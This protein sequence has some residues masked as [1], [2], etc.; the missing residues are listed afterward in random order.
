MSPGPCTAAG[1]NLQVDPGTTRHASLLEDDGDLMPLS[2]GAIQ[3]LR[4][5]RHRE[6]PDGRIDVH[7]RRPQ[8]GGFFVDPVCEDL[9]LN[10]D[11]RRG[12]ASNPDEPHAHD[13]GGS[14]LQ[15]ALPTVEGDSGRGRPEVHEQGIL[16]PKGVPSSQGVAVS[17]AVRSMAVLQ[18]RESPDPDGVRSPV[19]DRGLDPSDAL[20]RRR[21]HHPQG[22]DAK[23]GGAE[24]EPGNG[25]DDDHAEGDCDCLALHECSSSCRWS[26]E[27][28]WVRRLG[29]C[30]P[31]CPILPAR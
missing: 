12:P 14:R 8:R 31:L 21:G 7:R 9:P 22:P 24:R 1:A 27:S 2:H 11:A 3:R 25:C 26:P 16:S 19:D 13:A 28:S 30:T 4:A 17:Q 10:R 6:G 18:H 20:A 15:N 29:N 23:P 5:H